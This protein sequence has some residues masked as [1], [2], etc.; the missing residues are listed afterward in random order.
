[1]G[2]DLVTK[3]RWFGECVAVGAVGHAGLHKTCGQ[4]PRM[5][6]ADEERADAAAAA[7][8]QSQPTAWSPWA[9][10]W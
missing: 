2:E 7:I 1:M 3:G 4:P 9:K 8:A 6:T 10:W 5:T